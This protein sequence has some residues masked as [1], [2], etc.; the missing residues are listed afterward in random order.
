MNVAAL[1][2]QS[3]VREIAGLER[4]GHDLRWVDES[5]AAVVEIPLVVTGSL[6]SSNPKDLR[7]ILRA[8]MRAGLATLMVP[9]FRPCNLADVLGTPSDIEVLPLETEALNWDDTEYR[10]PGSVVFR[11]KLHVNKWAIVPGAGAQLMSFQPTTARG[12]VVL[13]AAA[14]TGRRVGSQVAHQRQLLNALLAICV[15]KKEEPFLEAVPTGNGSLSP[16]ELLARHPEHGPGMLIALLFG[17]S[18]SDSAQVCQRARSVVGVE[19]DPGVVEQLA[20]RMH[21]DQHDIEAALAGAG[22]SPFVRKARQ[23][24]PEVQHG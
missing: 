4:L 13:C 18:A 7:R 1:S 10:I 8:R 6:A 22:W 3:D 24:A 9:R 11:T 2:T 5:A 16:S 14:V 15:V 23:S 20:R 17:A 12:R 19:L 21:G